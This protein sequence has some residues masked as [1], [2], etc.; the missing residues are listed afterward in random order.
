MKKLSFVAFLFLAFHFTS[1]AQNFNGYAVFGF[2]GSQVIGDAMTGYNKPGLFAGLKVAFPFKENIEISTALNYVQKGSRRMYLRDG[3]PAGSGAWHV[4]RAN[5][6]EVPLL[7]HMDLH[8]LPWPVKLYAGASGARLLNAKIDWQQGGFEEALNVRTYDVSYHYGLSYDMSD[9]WMFSITN[10]H[11]FLSF[12]KQNFAL[13]FYKW[14]LGS[15][16]N[17]LNFEFAY[18]F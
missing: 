5:Y 11:S 15:Y 16:H 17:V 13:V 3:S 8:F 9:N 10:S 2:N 14:R 18:K 6:V 7:L 1:N 12:D 4:M